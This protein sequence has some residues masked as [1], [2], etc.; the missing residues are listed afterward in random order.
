MEWRVDTAGGTACRGWCQGR[1]MRANVVWNFPRI[2]DFG[3]LLLNIAGEILF[4]VVEK[5]GEG[6]GP[7]AASLP[8]SLQSRVPHILVDRFYG[9]TDKRRG[10]L[11]GGLRSGGRLFELFQFL[12]KPIELI[13][14]DVLWEVVIIVFVI[15]PRLWIIEDPFR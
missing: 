2:K 11:R 6:N 14:A 5:S 1:G 9:G 4:R 8:N 13:S 3:Q 10:L 12:R 7:N 15:L